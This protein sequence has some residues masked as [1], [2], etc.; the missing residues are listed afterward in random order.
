MPLGLLNSFTRGRCGTQEYAFNAANSDRNLENGGNGVAAG[1]P[2][3]KQA[4]AA[5]SGRSGSNPSRSGGLC[6]S[7]AKSR[8]GIQRQP[9]SSAVVAAETSSAVAGRQATETIIG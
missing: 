5:L 6:R 4:D 7:P 3:A 2:A 8:A 1:C 9:G